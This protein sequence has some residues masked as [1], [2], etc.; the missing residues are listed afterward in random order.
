MA[1]TCFGSEG[2][3]TWRQQLKY[4]P[5]SLKHVSTAAVVSARWKSSSFDSAG[6]SSH[7]AA[8]SNHIVS[9]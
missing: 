7:I 2:L 5:L 3:E 1:F 4:Q 9:H 6:T 8:T